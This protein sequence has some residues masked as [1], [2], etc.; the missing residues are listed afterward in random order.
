MGCHGNRSLSEPDSKPRCSGA[1]SRGRVMYARLMEAPR[2]TSSWI[3]DQNPN[4]RGK[5][6][7]AFFLAEAL[8]RKQTLAE[9][10]AV[11]AAWVSLPSLP[12]SV[13]GGEGRGLFSV[14]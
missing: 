11:G 12:P 9:W 1:G 7:H 3:P 5:W 8:S 2:D 13:D 6:N 10:K 14:G 4:L